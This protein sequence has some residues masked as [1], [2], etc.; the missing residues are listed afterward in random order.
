MTDT[1]DFFQADP[2]GGA[3]YTNARHGYQAPEL[4]WEFDAR[5]ETRVPGTDE[6]IVFG[7]LRST[8]SNEWKGTGMIDRDWSRFG[9]WKLK[10][11][12]P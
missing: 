6:R 7:F 3:I 10:E 8:D 4:V 1:T 9:P 12:S 11:T 2:G 5:F